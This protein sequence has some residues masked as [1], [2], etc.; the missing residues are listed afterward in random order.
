V[1]NRLVR[2]RVIVPER[3]NY[4]DQIE[5]IKHRIISQKPRLNLAYFIPTDL[6][7]FSCTYCH[8]VN[9]IPPGYRKR[10]MSQKVAFASA[11]FYAFNVY[12]H[13]QQPPRAIFYG[14]EPLLNFECVRLITN[15][16][17]KC[18]TKIDPRV[19]T[20]V[21][22]LTNGS[23]VTKEV[24]KR[25]RKLGVNVDVSI[26]GVEATTNIERRYRPKGPGTLDS[27]IKGFKILKK[28]G[29]NPGISCTIGRYNVGRLPEIAD[30]FSTVLK[31]RSVVFNIMFEFPKKKNPYLADMDRVSISLLKAYEILR[32]HKIYEDRIGRHLTS[33]GDLKFSVYDCAGCGDQLV[34][35]PNGDIGPCHAYLGSRKYFFGN[36]LTRE[37]GIF[38]SRTLKTWRR[39]TPFNIKECLFCPAIG[40]CG[41]GCA[42]QSE[43]KS[44]SLFG[45]DK[46]M[47]VFYKD[48]FLKWYIE[49]RYNQSL[50]K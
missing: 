33:E 5:T 9:G 21:A 41:G 38:E 31:P 16:I 45:P 14:G 2:E 48:F 30:Y 1:F 39:H 37:K 20:R 18:E 43:I 23:L 17:K 15:I 34:F 24:A 50:L 6:C 3:Y 19:R 47:C 42:Q 32:R 46:R 22:L 4:K 36:I 49:D 44:G 11:Q 27:A 25:L 40:I 7:N 13:I 26:D 29:L 35:S 28:E 8:I 10:D 12:R